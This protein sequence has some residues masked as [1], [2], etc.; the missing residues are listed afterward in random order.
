LVLFLTY[1]DIPR[2]ILNGDNC[3]FGYVVV[4]NHEIRPEGAPEEDDD[5]DHVE[6][7][8]EE[9]EDEE[10]LIELAEDNSGFQEIIL[11]SNREEAANDGQIEIGE[12]ENYAVIENSQINP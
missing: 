4:G 10:E 3:R 8:G 11:S 2:Y 7:E 6:L 9:L 5:S 12:E 1:L